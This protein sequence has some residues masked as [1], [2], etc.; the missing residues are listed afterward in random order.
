M[1]ET[2]LGGAAKRPPPRERGHH[3]KAS[4]DDLLETSEFLLKE[5]K[6]E[7]LPNRSYRRLKKGDT[8]EIQLEPSRSLHLTLAK[9]RFTLVPGEP[10]RRIDERGAEA[11]VPTGKC[12][13]GR[14]PSVDVGVNEGYRSVS[15]SRAILE[16]SPG[17]QVKF[18]DISPY[19]AYLLRDPTE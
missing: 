16:V 7:K 18:T 12:I 3:Q 11:I 9:H 14:G 13:V 19:G 10:Y 8:V 1:V 17:G 5:G 15:R 4:K 2:L 6:P